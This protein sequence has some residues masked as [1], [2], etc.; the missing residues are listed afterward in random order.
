MGSSCDWRL[1]SILNF[2][3][4]EADTAAKRERERQQHFPVQGDQRDFSSIQAAV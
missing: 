3:F 2:C 1:L 4:L